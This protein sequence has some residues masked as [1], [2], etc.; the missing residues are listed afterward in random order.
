MEMGASQP[1]LRMT[2]SVGRQHSFALAS[3][4]G[5]A[6]PVSLKRRF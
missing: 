1:A 6:R 5:G 2:G 3:R 4:M